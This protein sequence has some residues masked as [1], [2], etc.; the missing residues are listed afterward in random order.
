MAKKMSKLVLYM[1][2]SVLLDFQI[3]IDRA[4]GFRCCDAMCCLK[5]AVYTTPNGR[6]L[7]CDE[8]HKVYVIGEAFKKS[9]EAKNEFTLPVQ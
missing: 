1:E 3:K 9:R 2:G 4:K 7:F 5:R 8:H 6:T